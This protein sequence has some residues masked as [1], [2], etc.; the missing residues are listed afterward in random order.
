MTIETNHGPVSYKGVMV[1]STFMGLEEHRSELMDALSKEKLVPV[2]MEKYVPT[3]GDDVLSSSLDMVRE[4]SAYI[5]IISHRCGQVP[6]CKERN[7]H[8]YSI[9][10]L[11]FEEARNL[12]L[13][14]LVF[15][16][17]RRH[18]VTVDDVEK[19]AE[20]NEKLKAFRKRAKEGRI[21]V[22]FNSLEDFTKQAIHAVARLRGYLEQQA[23]PPAPHPQDPAFIVETTESRHDAI[24]APP[25]FYA[26]PPYIGSHK[27]IGRNAQLELLDDWASPA[28]PHPV[29]LFEA[30]G[31]AGKSIL[32]WEW[33]TRRAVGIRDDWEGR[34]WYSFYER[35]AVMA[36]FC[37]RA[38]AYITGQS[39]KELRKK[40]TLELS[41]LL[42][43][44]LRAK[45]WLIVLDGLERV[46]VA[47]HRID[48]AQLADEDAGKT[49]EIAHRDP[50]AAIRPEDDELLRS[51]AGAAASKLLLTSRL[52]PRVLL[53]A[54]S[55]SKPGVLRERLPGLRP[56]D[57]EALFRSCGVTG[58]SK[59]I[60]H[61]LQFHCDCHPLVTGVLAGLVTGY[62]PDRGNFDSW[63][64]DPNGGGQ[65]NLAD[66]DLIQKRN[67]ILEAALAA[68]DEKSRQLLSTLALLS[69]AVDYPTLS[70]LNPHL[71]PDPEEDQDRLTS[72][73]FNSTQQK[74]QETVSDLERRGLLQYDPITKRHDLHPVVRGISAGGLRQKE[75]ER[76]G[77]RVV[78]HFSQKA[79]RPY[80]EA[81]TIEDLQDG[82]QVFRVL[83]HMGRHQQAFNDLR[84]GLCIALL[85]NLEAYTEVLSLLRPF[86]PQNWTTLPN[87]LDQWDA[88]Y[89][90]SGTGIALLRS[91]ALKEAL[92]VY[93]CLMPV[94]IEQKNWNGLCEKLATIS[95]VL[96]AE[97]CLTKRERCLVLALDLA[98][99]GCDDEDLFRARLVRF[100]Q[101]SG[102]GK[103]MD[104]EEMW[105]LLDPMGRNWDRAIYRP[106]AAEYD[107]AK[108][109]FYKGDLTNEII[110]RAEQLAKTGKNRY[111]IRQL[112]HLRGEWHLQ[113]GRY[114]PAAESL[115]KAVRMAREAG[116]VDA[117]SETR[118]ALARMHLGQLSKPRNEAERL[119]RVRKP[120]HH[121]LAELWLA[122]G[123]LDQAKK[124]AQLAYKWAWADGEPYVRRYELNMAKALLHKLGVEPPILKPYDPAKDE[125][126][127]WEDEVV[128]AIDKLRAENEAK[129]SE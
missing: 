4:S 94:M 36:D 19:D 88:S 52:T 109:R 9:T 12:G 87:E 78:D 44:H 84:D 102:I 53:N 85:F 28:D 117:G 104:A 1:S 103:W 115:Q 47:Y 70:A 23:Q 82:L 123:D 59:G 79:H 77:Q 111:V 25:A 29:L 128:A 106:G 16:M 49:D 127:P 32:T 13:P 64:A 92:A 41:E 56:P 68:L 110:E 50:C 35:G 61:Y 83:L 27:F 96:T 71:P 118:Y 122:I 22:E 42:L 121:H 14:T 24:P 126:L 86:Y 80:E 54:A 10:R 114:T 75:K 100:R 95:I 48:A 72:T 3:P 51:L 66:L 46:L 38:L 15:I 93:G 6:D 124:H 76:Y 81:E 34:F 39:L 97:N 58:D 21:Y 62:L 2:V 65:L 63:A 112:N 5:G 55:Q 37:R 91:G 125:K 108:F 120:A 89:V 11:E 129:K 30:I 8:G 90:A 105:Q 74:L 20:K 107:Y 116:L 119:A 101:L 57:A 73:E 7:P 45:P 69:E 43:H 113:Q 99:Q 18:P 40:K 67:H 17:G 33:V 98:E 26:E 60:Q 31:G